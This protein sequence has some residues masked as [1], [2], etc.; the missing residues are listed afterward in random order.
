MPQIV[1]REYFNEAAVKQLTDMG[2]LPRNVF[3]I[4]DIEAVDGEEIAAAIAQEAYDNDPSSFTEGGDIVIVDPPEFA[5]KYYVEPEF[6]AT[7]WASR[8]DED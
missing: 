7:F 2:T 3:E 6:R 8:Q 1:W 4:E 5:G